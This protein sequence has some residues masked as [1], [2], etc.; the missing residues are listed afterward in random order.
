MT[1]EPVSAKVKISHFFT[2]RGGFNSGE[3]IRLIYIGSREV[4]LNLETVYSREKWIY[5]EFGR[6]DDIFEFN[7]DTTLKEIN[8]RLPALGTISRTFVIG[9]ITE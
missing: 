4:P 9:E 8:A 3:K 1:S 5:K 6:N 7:D 2:L